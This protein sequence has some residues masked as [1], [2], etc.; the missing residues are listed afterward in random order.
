MA[1]DVETEPVDLVVPRPVDEIVDHE[2]LHHGVLGGGVLAAGARLDEALLVQPVVVAGHDL[3]EH[4]L[5][6]EAARVRMVVDDVHNDAQAR[7]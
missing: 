6:V 2:A 7:L 5:V 1:H 4:R 3:V